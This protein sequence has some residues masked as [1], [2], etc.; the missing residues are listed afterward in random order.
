MSREEERREPEV[1]AYAVKIPRF[2]P[3][4]LRLQFAWVEAQF[5]LRG[6]TAQLTKFH[7][8]LAN[9]SQVIATNARDLLMNPPEENSYD[10]LKVNLIN[11]ITVSEQQ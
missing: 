7:H 3:S 4:D 2:W 10:V 5:V 8:I 9:P 11:R 6:I 1:A